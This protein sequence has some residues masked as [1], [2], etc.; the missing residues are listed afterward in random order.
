MKPS[1]NEHSR[2]QAAALHSS[3]LKEIE[4]ASI[5]RTLRHVNPDAKSSS[6]S[7]VEQSAPSSVN[8]IASSSPSVMKPSMLKTASGSAKMSLTQSTSKPIQS[9][10]VK[11]SS[12]QST[13]VKPNPVQ[14]SVRPDST[15]STSYKSNTV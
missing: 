5:Q 4:G 14:S 6:V 13:F 12:A 1:A 9:T 2:P 11:P 15:Q 3:L 7:S 10:S 8:R